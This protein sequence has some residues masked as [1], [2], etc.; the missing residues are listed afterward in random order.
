[1]GTIVVGAP[2]GEMH[3]LATSFAADILRAHRF[4]VVDLGADVPTDA[5][6]ECVRRT[7]RLVAVVIGVMTT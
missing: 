7:N 1:M 2:T 3:G 4:D 5:F 6:V